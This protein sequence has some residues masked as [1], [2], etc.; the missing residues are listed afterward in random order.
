[1]ARGKGKRGRGGRGASNSRGTRANPETGDDS[2]VEGEKER[3]LTLGKRSQDS[4]GAA[5][6]AETSTKQRKK[7]DEPEE[8]DWGL[9]IKEV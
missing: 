4:A 3:E 6:G 5:G 8:E 1:M 7:Q 9:C 2:G